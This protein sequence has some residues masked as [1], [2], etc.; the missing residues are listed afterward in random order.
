M[1]W[2]LSRSTCRRPQE[3]HIETDIVIYTTSIMSIGNEHWQHAMTL[4]EDARA[5]D[6]ENNVPRQQP[7]KKSK[8][9]SKLRYVVFFSNQV[10]ALVAQVDVG[11][12]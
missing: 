1:L 9:S 12:G 11:F 4:L 3:R 6:A 2:D 8:E 5:L 10:L 7:N